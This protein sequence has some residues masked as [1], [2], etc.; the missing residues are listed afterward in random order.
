MKPTFAKL[1]LK[2][3]NN[4]KT[5]EINNQEIEIKQYLPITDKLELISS[6]INW[7]A[8]A[9]NFANPVKIEVFTKLE[10]VFRYTNLTFTEK[11]REDPAK[12][13]DLLEENCI[14]EQI[15]NMIPESEL[16]YL[17]K[18]TAECVTAIYAYN[19]SV[20]GV[21]E[22]LNNNYDETNFDINKLQEDL[23]GIGDVTLLQDVLKKLG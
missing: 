14:F 8:D 13:Y 4:V 6:V 18:S 15:F 1:G 16:N 23:A 22:R 20:M 17:M 11:Q 12:L 10:V 21:L 5:I 2:L 9:N 7:A 3:N 19:N